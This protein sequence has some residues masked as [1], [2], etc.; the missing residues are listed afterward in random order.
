MDHGFIYFVTDAK[1]CLANT[2][3]KDCLFGARAYYIPQLSTSDREEG[4]IPPQIDVFAK[5]E[6]TI[7]LLKIFIRNRFLTKD[8]FVNQTFEPLKES[9]DYWKNM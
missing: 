1:Q 8:G 4:K 9:L 6:L 5:P 7:P 3:K 2:A